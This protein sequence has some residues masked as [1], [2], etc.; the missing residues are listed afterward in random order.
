MVD[1][2]KLEIINFKHDLPRLSRIGRIG[3]YEKIP[4]AVW[5]DADAKLMVWR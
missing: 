1:A 5:A 4:V 3:V 2:M